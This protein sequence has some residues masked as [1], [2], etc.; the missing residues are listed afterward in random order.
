MD[1]TYIPASIDDQ[2]QVITVGIT[3]LRKTRKQTIIT[4]LRIGFNTKTLPTILNA[5]TDSKRMC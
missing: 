3:L 1:Y 5:T 4:Y 2:K